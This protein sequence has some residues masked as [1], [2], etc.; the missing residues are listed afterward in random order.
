MGLRLELKMSSYNNDDIV[1][2]E[3]GIG[4]T[5]TSVTPTRRNRLIFSIA[6]VILLVVCVLFGV[7]ATRTTTTVVVPPSS[8]SSSSVEQAT[9][10]SITTKATVLDLHKSKDKIIDADPINHE[11]T[12]PPSPSVILYTRQPTYKPTDESKKS[13]KDRL[14]KK[15]KKDETYDIIDADPINHENT[16]P[17]SPSVILYTHQPTYK[18]TEEK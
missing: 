9:T 17:P 10:T 4:K 8:S 3:N 18:P 11:N 12:P 5:T 14:L 16:P 13:N 7:A 2:I 1:L 6:G 15:S